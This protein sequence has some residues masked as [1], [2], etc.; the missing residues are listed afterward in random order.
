[1]MKGILIAVSIFVEVG[2]D[3][4]HR[5]ADGPLLLM[6]NLGEYDQGNVI[7]VHGANN[8]IYESFQAM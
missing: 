6:D 4:L 5:Q 7:L 1:M 2:G 3:Y 8:I